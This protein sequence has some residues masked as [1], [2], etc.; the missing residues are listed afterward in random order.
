MIAARSLGSVEANT[1]FLTFVAIVFTAY[2]I[3]S[4]LSTEMTR[5]HA[6]TGRSH[7]AVGPR[8][9]L[10]TAALA[11]TCS[12]AML[13]AWP[14]WRHV[15][16]RPSVPL[17]ALLPAAILGY[18]GHAALVGGL[19][20]RR[21]WRTCSIA[22]GLEAGLRLVAAVVVSLSGASMFGLSFAT[23]IGAW[24]W[25]LLLVFSPDSRSVLTSRLDHPATRMAARIAASMSA[26]AAS[27][28]LVVGFPVLLSL[29]TPALEYAH[30]AP[31]IL[32]IT[33]TRAPLLIPLNA[34]QGVAVSLFIHRGGSLPWSRRMS[35]ATVGLVAVGLLGAYVF[36]PLILGWLFGSTYV[37]SGTTLVLLTLAAVLLAAL[38]LTGAFC[39]ALDQHA[40]YLAGWLTTLGGAIVLLALPGHMDD[41]AVRAL[42]LA[43]TAGILVH[44]ARFRRVRGREGRSVA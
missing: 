38:T 15:L 42:L 7:T 36:G 5:A 13:A 16:E 21:L 33:L 17:L 27:A 41:R 23:V 14:L 44:L 10:V 39:Q 18:V 20:G 35:V 24:G 3:L 2:G 25:V 9:D 31:L 22:I 29:S 37:V 30:G 6:A 4:G 11:L 12:A 1:Q 8:T 34:Y 43:P 28:A 19:A 32:A 40:W 26:Q